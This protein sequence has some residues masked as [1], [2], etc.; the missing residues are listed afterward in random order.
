MSKLGQLEADIQ[1]VTQGLARISSDA[2]PAL[3]A[4]LHQAMALANSRKRKSCDVSMPS[5]ILGGLEAKRG[6]SLDGSSAGRHPDIVYLSQE[7]FSDHGNGTRH[8]LW[9]GKGTNPDFCA[10]T[11]MSVCR[12]S[13][14]VCYHPPCLILHAKSWDSLLGAFPK[15]PP[16][17]HCKHTGSEAPLF[18]PGMLHTYI[19]GL[20]KILLI[21]WQ[22]HIC[23]LPA[24]AGLTSDN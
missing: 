2:V 22:H 15:F 3:P 1:A 14:S 16:T 24:L 4:S 17:R 9:P 20:Q 11:Q 12:T 18:Q 6:H 23:I 10:Q 5:E 8:L 7:F 13:I 19:Q 21:M